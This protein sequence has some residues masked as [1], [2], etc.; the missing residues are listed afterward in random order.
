MGQRLGDAAVD[1]GDRRQLALVDDEHVE[2][3][4]QC[5]RQFARRRGV[6]HNADACVVRRDRVGGNRVDRCFEL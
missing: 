4:N 1:A 6:E 2:G 5:R 3:V